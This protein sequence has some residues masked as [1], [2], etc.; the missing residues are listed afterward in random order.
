MCYTLCIRHFLTLYS[1]YSALV[2]TIQSVD[3]DTH[4]D[5]HYQ[6]PPRHAD[7]LEVGVD[8]IGYPKKKK[9]LLHSI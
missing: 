6:P 8:E 1:A 5:E 7:T 9:T 3:G 4:G 2:D